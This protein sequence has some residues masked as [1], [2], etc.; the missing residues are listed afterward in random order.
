MHINVFKKLHTYNS[1]IPIIHIKMANS[2]S[3]NN[4]EVEESYIKTLIGILI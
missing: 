2:D 3:K 1:Y 4:S